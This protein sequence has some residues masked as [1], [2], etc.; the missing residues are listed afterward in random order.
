MKYTLY[1][2]TA[3]NGKIYIGITSTKPEDRWKS[4]TGYVKNKHFYSAI[5]K[6]GWKN[7]R[8]EILLTDLTQ[9]EAFEKEIELIKKYKSNEREFGYNHGIGGE[10]GSTGTKWSEESRKHHMEAILSKP[11]TP[12][13][14]TK[15]KI[16]ESLKKYYSENPWKKRKP[17]G[18]RTG[19]R[20]HNG[21]KKKKVLCVETGDIFLGAKAAA[22]WAGLKSRQNIY[23]CCCNVENRQTAGGYHWKYYYEEDQDEH[24]STTDT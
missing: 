1:K 15:K 14:E 18:N 7:I 12:S 9:E 6:Y 13:D 16:S 3:P 10:H 22:N 5:K 11:R 4:G 19:N 2:H 20:T 23:Y 21:G 24:R 17:G 8:H